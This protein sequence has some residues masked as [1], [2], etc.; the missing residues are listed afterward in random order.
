MQALGKA[1]KG[2]D[3]HVP[4]RDSKLT[5]LLQDSLSGGSKVLMFVNVSPAAYNHSETISSLNFAARCRAIELGKAVKQEESGE[6]V[7][8]RK[9]V[10]SLKKELEKAKAH[11][12]AKEAALRE[13]EKRE[14]TL[15]SKMNEA[16]NSTSAKTAASEAMAQ[17]HKERLDGLMDERAAREQEC[18]ELK[19]L[20]AA[21]NA[22]TEHKEE[23]LTRVTQEISQLHEDLSAAKEAKVAA[24]GSAMGIGIELK[25]AQRELESER[26]KSAKSETSVVSTLKQKLHAM[27]LKEKEL[28]STVAKLTKE[29]ET[30]ASVLESK[31][32]TIASMEEDLTRGR[33]DYSVLLTKMTMQRYESGGGGGGGGSM[34]GVDLTAAPMVNRPL[35]TEILLR[36]AHGAAKASR[37]PT[38]HK[39][40]SL[41][42]PAASQAAKLYVPSGFVPLKSS[43]GDAASSALSG[44]QSP[45]IG[46]GSS[47]GDRPSGGKGGLLK[48]GNASSSLPS[49]GRDAVS[50][51]TAKSLEERRLNV[52]KLSAMADEDQPRGSPLPRDSEDDDDNE[53][54]L[55]QSLASSE[56]NSVNSERDEAS[57]EGGARLKDRL[58]SVAGKSTAS[59]QSKSSS[60]KTSSSKNVSTY[61]LTLSGDADATDAEFAGFQ[62]QFVSGLSITVVSQGV[63]SGKP[64]RRQRT[65]TIRFLAK[66]GLTLVWSKRESLVLAHVTDV[67]VG[68][69]N[70][71]RNS[72]DQGPAIEPGKLKSRPSWSLSSSG[73]AA[74]SAGITVDS[75][76]AFCLKYLGST[77]TSS[78]NSANATSPRAAKA[79]T[80]SEA[81]LLVLE[82]SEPSQRN[83]LVRCFRR[84][85][86]QE[87]E[88]S[89]FL[90]D[91]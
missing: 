13:A 69:P 80:S 52:A 88:R 72:S 12:E 62:A 85:A 43:T 8:L 17:Q 82:V 38:A 41:P 40:V 27:E 42:S 66:R 60:S 57:A 81:S 79:T 87:R 75:E 55:R 23:E 9:D 61:D 89:T 45:G 37:L 31:E 91:S 25:N 19:E 29:A 28:T 64:K 36:K 35:V 21:A 50:M 18:A 77:T 46:R 3:R 86:H 22:S 20:L 15:S 68:G 44:P 5:Y 30:A 70:A 78:T 10:A 47:V 71:D 2:A 16:L 59:E 24:E 83:H 34:D 49:P 90:L 32:K 11:G 58:A 63:S 65:F 7:Q 53:R 48:G 33:A 14:M 26:E 51:E 76:K 74:S 56:F 4:Y 67:F 84:L 1:S 54:A 73:T 39:G 6:G